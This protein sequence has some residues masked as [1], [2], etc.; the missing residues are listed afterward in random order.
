MTGFFRGR[1]FRT[2]LVWRSMAI[3]SSLGKEDYRDE[4]RR[5]VP[6]EYTTWITREEST[7]NK[8]FN[9]IQSE[10]TV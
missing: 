7:R 6:I 10:Q 4:D 8:L 2:F 9:G 3:A 5:I 1:T